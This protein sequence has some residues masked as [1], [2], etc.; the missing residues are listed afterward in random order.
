MV[1]GAVDVQGNIDSRKGWWME[2]QHLG[3]SSLPLFFLSGKD[4]EVIKDTVI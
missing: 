2:F 4:L 1:A 3:S